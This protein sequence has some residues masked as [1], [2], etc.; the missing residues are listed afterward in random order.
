MK[1][2]ALLLLLAAAGQSTQSPFVYD[3]HIAAGAM[4][5]IQ[6]DGTPYV[7]KGG[8]VAV[9]WIPITKIS[10]HAQQHLDVDSETFQPIK[11]NGAVTCHWTAPPGNH[12]ITV[13]VIPSSGSGAWAPTQQ[14]DLQLRVGGTPDDD[15]QDDEQDDT[16]DDDQ[17]DTD[18][19][20]QPAG[21]WSK[22][23]HAIVKWGQSNDGGPNGQAAAQQFAAVFREYGQQRANSLQL[24]Q[25]TQETRAEIIRR[26]RLANFS[27]FSNLMATLVKHL[28][29][30]KDELATAASRAA[31]W[32]AIAKGFDEIGK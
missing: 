3:K 24:G 4:G 19:D 15:E 2:A 31:A 6:F 8:N 25:L 7:E 20:D 5:Q 16:D 22:F 21:D 32:E 13:V 29:E 14:Y 10:Y 18:D 28:E 11:Y 23:T 1:T 9:I 12:R 26:V 17:D 30:R 27:P